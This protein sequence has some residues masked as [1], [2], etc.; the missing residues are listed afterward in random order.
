MSGRD[1]HD[2]A[3]DREPPDETVTWL[4]EQVRLIDHEEGFGL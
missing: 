4:S 3:P 2:A 1:E